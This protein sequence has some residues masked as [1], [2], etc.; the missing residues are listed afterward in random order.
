MLKE[1]LE[2]IQVN[3]QGKAIYT[4]A[5]KECTIEETKKNPELI[6][7]HNSSSGSNNFSLKYARVE[8]GASAKKAKHPALENQDTNT[9]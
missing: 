1:Y 8:I 5:K 7:S 9:R 4:K 3:W 6:E 2:K